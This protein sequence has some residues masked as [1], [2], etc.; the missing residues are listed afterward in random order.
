MQQYS[1]ESHAGRHDISFGSTVSELLVAQGFACGGGDPAVGGQ[2]R[3]THRHHRR[4]WNSSRPC[5]PQR[6]TPPQRRHTV[7]WALRGC[8]LRVTLDVVDN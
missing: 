3:T 5:F 4:T 7:F 2:E 1:L 6:K 8:C